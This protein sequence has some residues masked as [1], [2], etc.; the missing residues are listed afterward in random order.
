MPRPR[1]SS[2]M[3]GVMPKPAAAFS[4][5]AMTRSIFFAATKPG[6]RSRTMV[7]PGRPKISPIN[8]MRTNAMVADARK[9]VF[10]VCFLFSNHKHPDPSTRVSRAGD[11]AREPSLTQDD[12]FLFWSVSSGS[13]QPWSKNHNHRWEIN[14][15][16]AP[17]GCAP[18]HYPNTRDLCKA[19]RGQ[20]SAAFQRKFLCA[21]FGQARGARERQGRQLA[22]WCNNRGWRGGAGNWRNRRHIRKYPDL[23]WRR[24]SAASKA[25]RPLWSRRN[26]RRRTPWCG[27]P[28]R[29]LRR[30]I[31]AV[32]PPPAAAWFRRCWRSSSANAAESHPLRGGIR[33]RRAT[34]RHGRGRDR[35]EGRYRYMPNSAAAECW[36]R[37]A[38]G[39]ATDIRPWAGGR[40]RRQWPGARAHLSKSDHAD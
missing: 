26:K 22:D 7:R 13:V 21:C 28:V 2:T 37:G 18:E 25:G 10:A 17:G 8:K 12:S 38:P 11:D 9:R 6:S 14:A 3:G 16:F 5:L 23:G 31:V 35:N 24:S 33:Q 27:C 34:G 36:R 20:G 19:G 15:D 32:K 39:R 30:A 1:S 40:W 4:A 29:Y